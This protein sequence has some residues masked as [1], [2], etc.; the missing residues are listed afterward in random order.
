MDVAVFVV[1]LCHVIDCPST[2]SK[3]YGDYALCSDL[4]FGCRLA[5]F[6]EKKGHC[7]GLLFLE[8]VN[9]FASLFCSVARLNLYSYSLQQKR[10]L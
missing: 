3:I 1:P 9:C 2:F 8:S 7:I 4:I 6:K 5:A 10:P